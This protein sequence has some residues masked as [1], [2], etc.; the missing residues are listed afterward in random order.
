MGVATKHTCIENKNI[1]MKANIQNINFTTMKKFNLEDLKKESNKQELFATPDGYFDKLPR[2]I[3]QEINQRK[4]SSFSLLTVYQAFMQWQTLRWAVPALACVVLVFVG[5]QF[6]R[7][8]TNLANNQNL[9][10]TD[11]QEV[12][13][14]DI[15]AYLLT[16]DLHEEE[17]VR[18]CVANENELHIEGLPSEEISEE[19]IANELDLEDY[20]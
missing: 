9:A 7:Q 20:L 4:A 10:T 15:Q 19:V 18:M 17:I 6:Y 8:P 16:T 1:R 12:S 5:I 14:Q 11:W 2:Q 3:Q 13:A